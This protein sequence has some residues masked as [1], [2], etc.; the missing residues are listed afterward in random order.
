M[1]RVGQPRAVLSRERLRDFL[2]HVVRRFARQ[3]GEIVGVE[4]AE[5]VYELVARELLQ[6]RAACRLG[7]FHQRG[8]GLFGLELPKDQ[9]A[10][11][12]GQRIEDRRDVRG[13]LGSQ[14]ALQLDEVLSMLHLLEQG[15]ARG[16]LPAGERGQHAMTVEETHDLV[17]LVPDCLTSVSG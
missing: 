15:V 6:Q 13:M 9:Q 10:I 7:G 4:R 14:M 16:L 5:H 3:I 12:A 2:Q 11:V 8:A 1:A 17:A